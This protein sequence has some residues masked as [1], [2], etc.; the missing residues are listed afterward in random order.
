[1]SGILYGAVSVHRSGVVHEKATH[2]NLRQPI[3]SK[4]FCINFIKDVGAPG[5]GSI[6]GNGDVKTST[7]QRCVHLAPQK[8]RRHLYGTTRQN[9]K[10]LLLAGSL[11]ATMSSKATEATTS[12]ISAQQTKMQSTGLLLHASN[13]IV[14]SRLLLHI[15]CHLWRLTAWILFC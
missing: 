1:M 3:F 4:G 13:R 15:C 12:S 7:G 11:S 2:R 9:H 10:C 6:D 5:K 14:L 8:L